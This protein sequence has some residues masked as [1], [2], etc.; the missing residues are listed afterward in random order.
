M[1][2]VRLIQGKRIIVSA[3]ETMVHFNFSTFCETCGAFSPTRPAVASPNFKKI[4]TI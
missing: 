4:L 3:L 1:N 2:V